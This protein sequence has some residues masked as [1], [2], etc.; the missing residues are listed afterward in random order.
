MEPLAIPRTPT[1]H[2]PSHQAS[3]RLSNDNYI[4]HHIDSP[5]LLLETNHCH[6]VR[7]ISKGT[8]QELVQRMGDLYRNVTRVEKGQLS[9]EFMR[10][11]YYHRKHTVRVLNEASSPPLKV[12]HFRRKIH[13]YA[14]RNG[15]Q[16]S[17]EFP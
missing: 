9:D 7:A 1:S 4:S 5:F 11:I 16:N 15:V 10:L 17:P 14:V 8:R 3:S 13:N 2:W 6:M 12:N